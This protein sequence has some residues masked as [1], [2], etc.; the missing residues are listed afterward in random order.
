M[1]FLFIFQ[2][3]KSKIVQKFKILPFRFFKTWCNTV[4]IYNFVLFLA[5]VAKKDHFHQTNPPKNS[6]PSLIKLHISK[7]A[8]RNCVGSEKSQHSANKH[9]IQ[10]RHAPRVKFLWLQYMQSNIMRRR[11]PFLT[12]SRSFNRS[13]RP[14]TRT[15]SHVVSLPRHISHTINAQGNDHSFPH[16]YGKKRVI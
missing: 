16:T 2:I 15:H 5:I 3:K 11:N 14:K 4:C 13:P 9:Y 1:P 6:I 7:Y 8:H 10:M 12:L